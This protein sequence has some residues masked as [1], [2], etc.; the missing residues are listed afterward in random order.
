MALTESSEFVVFQLGEWEY[1][2]DI[3]QVQR[4]RGYR[5]LAR[6]A[7]APDFVEGAVQSDGVIMPIVDLRLHVG[8]ATPTFDH[9]T[10][11]IILNVPDRTV[12]LVVDSASDVVSLMAGE[13]LPVSDLGAA[14][15]L[16]AD[17]LTGVAT[18]EGRSLI[19]VDID[20]LMSAA[21][22]GLGARN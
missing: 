16:G 15:T 5:S 22:I 3:R 7:S 17:Y 4:L 6:T 19:L 8:I 21:E 13:L 14:P 2:I 18:Y 20:R 10:A 12:G 9:F 11:V 1:G